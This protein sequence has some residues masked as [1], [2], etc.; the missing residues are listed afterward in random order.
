MSLYFKGRIVPY[1]RIVKQLMTVEPKGKHVGNRIWLW[2]NPE[3]KKA[4]IAGDEGNDWYVIIA[5]GR[6]KEEAM[7][8]LK[9]KRE[10]NEVFNEFVQE[11]LKTSP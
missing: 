5:H 8:R 6:N 10:N 4:L 1:E 7:A 2:E 3:T 11:I 9:A